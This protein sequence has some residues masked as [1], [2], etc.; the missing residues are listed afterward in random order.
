[1]PRTVGHET[2]SGPE[3]DVDEYDMYTCL[4]TVGLRA[5]M[6]ASTLTMISSCTSSWTEE[7]MY[8]YK[9]ASATVMFLVEYVH[10]S[11]LRGTDMIIFEKTRG[12]Q[13]SQLAARLCRQDHT[14]DEMV[15]GTLPDQ[16]RD[17]AFCDET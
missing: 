3:N 14:L 13:S 5:E 2:S 6:F 9:Y 4:L 12:P 8:A 15:A 11:T 17:E 1:M 10:T 7:C 16:F